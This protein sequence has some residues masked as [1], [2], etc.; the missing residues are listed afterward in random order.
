M[1]KLFVF[2][3]FA[4]MAGAGVAGAQT[5][6]ITLED[7]WTKRTFSARGVYGIRSMADGE[8]YCTMSRTGI[9]KYSYATGEKVADVCLF[10]AP[11]LKKKAKPLPPMEGYEF[12]KDEQKILLSSGTMFRAKPLRRSATTASSA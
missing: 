8:H 6:N 11:D 4:L 2:M 9:A 3:A 10:N 5:K 12:S 7:I 1:K